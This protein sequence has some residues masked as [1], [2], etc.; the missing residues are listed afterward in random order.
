MKRGQTSFLLFLYIKT[1]SIDEITWHKSQA[2]LVFINAG[3]TF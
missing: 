1:V 2:S 3:Q